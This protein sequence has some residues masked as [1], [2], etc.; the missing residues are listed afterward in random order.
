MKKI[1]GLG[2]IF[3]VSFGLAGCG[4]SDSG[5]DTTESTSKSDVSSSV[6]KESSATSSEKSEA[7]DTVYEDKDSKIVIKNAE[8]LTSQYDE[9]VKIVA[10][11]IEYTNKGDKAQSPWFAFATSIKPIQETDVTEELLDGA[12]GLYPEDYKPDLVSM[13]DTDVKAG[14]TVDAVVGVQLKY[15]GSPLI[16]KD[17]MDE[18]TFER[19]IETTK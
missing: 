16:L 12:N 14:A 17:F 9:N 15:P 3:A 13:G 5:N 2:L 4:S 19:T 10:I 18:G 6:V 8:E 7:S 11:E 1:V